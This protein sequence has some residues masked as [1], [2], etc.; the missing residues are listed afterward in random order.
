MVCVARPIK[1]RANGG[2]HAV[3][4]AA[5][6]HDVGTGLGVRNGNFGQNIQGLIVENIACVAEQTTVPMIRIFAQANVGDDDEI[7]QFCFDGANG[8]LNDAI[9]G[10][11]FQ[12]NRVFFGG[13]A[14]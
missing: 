3:H 10:E 14:K 4:H 6:S 7:G 13:Q 9:V 11:V 1:T 2:N 12:A 8:L 5:G